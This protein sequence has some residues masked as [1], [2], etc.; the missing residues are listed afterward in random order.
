M[1]RP[2][3]VL[4]GACMEET[5]FRVTHTLHHTPKRLLLHVCFAV[6]AERIGR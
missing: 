2:G 4:S 3:E 5:S 1:T 6:G